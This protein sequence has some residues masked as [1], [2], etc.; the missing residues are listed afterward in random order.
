MPTKRQPLQRKLKPHITP[1]AL[2]VWRELRRLERAGATKGAE[3]SDLGKRLCGL[4]GCDWMTMQWPSTATSATLPAY[5]Q[6]RELQAEAWRQARAARV[7]LE[8]A[9]REQPET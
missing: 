3:Y 9:D 5:L 1:Q 7:A 6:G 4:V 2:A 8:Q